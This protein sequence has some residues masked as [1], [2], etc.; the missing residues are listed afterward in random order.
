MPETTLSETM[1]PAAVADRHLA[2]Y[3]E[4]DPIRRRA[5]LE[6]AWVPEGLLVDPPL[7]PAKGHDQLDDLF[8]I[9]QS[10]YPGHR[11]RR[12]T[13][14]DAHHE[15]GRYGW[16]LVGPDGAVAFVGVDVVEFAD[17]GRLAGVVGFLGDLAAIDA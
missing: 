5:L 8:A 14:V 4:P 3:G 9:V 12:T 17:D 13:A 2:A 11:F 15:F 16:E 1:S 6:A 7:D 10:H